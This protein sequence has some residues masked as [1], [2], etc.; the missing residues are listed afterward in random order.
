MALFFE[1]KAN[2]AMAL[3]FLLTTYTVVLYSYSITCLSRELRYLWLELKN[4]SV[5]LANSSYGFSFRPN[6]WVAVLSLL[7]YRFY[8]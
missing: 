2:A 4:W 5:C 6:Q 8:M 3:T 7:C 1:L